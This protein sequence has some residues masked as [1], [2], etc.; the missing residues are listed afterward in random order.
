M[1]SKTI[2]LLFCMFLLASAAG[3]QESEPARSKLVDDLRLELARLHHEID[4]LKALRSAD[5]VT[6]SDMLDRLEENLEKRLTY[7]ETKIDAVSRATAPV[8]FNP[9]MTAFINFAARGDS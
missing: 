4:S 7:L 1:W 3:A 9:G 5:L 2:P 8:A 6:Q